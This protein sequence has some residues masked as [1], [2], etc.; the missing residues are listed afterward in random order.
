MLDLEPADRDPLDEQP[1]EGCRIWTLQLAF[2]RLELPR[3]DFLR[4]QVRACQQFHPG[5][6]DAYR[7][8]L[9]LPPEDRLRIEELPDGG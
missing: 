5:L 6:F 7:E 2:Q 9:D 8:T 1:F 4:D 3:E